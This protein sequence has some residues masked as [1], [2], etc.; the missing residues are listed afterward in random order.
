MPNKHY[1]KGRR[2]EYLFI[3]ELRRWGYEARRTAG[4]HGPFDIV[5]LDQSEMFNHPVRLIQ[6]KAVKTERQKNHLLRIWKAPLRPN[7]HY[8]QEIIVRWNGHWWGVPPEHR[9]EHN[10]AHGHAAQS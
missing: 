1:L 2:A 5:A 4:S 9:H 7:P 10:Q 3:K 8:R 6:V